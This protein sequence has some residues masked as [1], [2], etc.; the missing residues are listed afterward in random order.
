MEPEI[1]LKPFVRKKSTGLSS[2]LIFQ[3]GELMSGVQTT[4]TE[5]S[6]FRKQRTKQAGGTA[7]AEGWN[8]SS[9]VL[10]RISSTNVSR[11]IEDDALTLTILKRKWTAIK[12]NDITVVPVVTVVAEGVVVLLLVV[13]SCLLLAYLPSPL[14]L[15]A[16]QVV[17]GSRL[18]S[19]GESH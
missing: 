8:T 15:A 17:V 10:L 4:G 13:H 5:F 18:R 19:R 11:Q 16:A 2:I 12:T 1:H 9:S 7:T 14:L 3:L 6:F